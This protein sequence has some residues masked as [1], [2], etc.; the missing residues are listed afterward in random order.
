VK[1]SQVDL[2]APVDSQLAAIKETL[3]A[4]TGIRGGKIQRTKG[5][6]TNSVGID[7]AA[8][9]GTQVATTAEL[10]QLITKVSDVEAKLNAL[11]DRMNTP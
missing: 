4:L 8:V 7:V 1:K 5:I 10:T 3:E 6:Q 11:I 9:A 2:S